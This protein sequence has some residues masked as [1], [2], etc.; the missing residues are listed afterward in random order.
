LLLAAGD[1]REHGGN[2]GYDDQPDVHYSWD[3][4]VHNYAGPQVGDR[5][6]LW[7]KER[8]LG[9]ST[10]EAIETRSDEKVRRRCPV[11]HLA[12]IKPRK[13]TTPRYKCYNCKEVFEEA[14]SRVATVT[15]YRTRH[16][17]GWTSLVDVL[18][19]SELRNLC[20]AP[21]SQLSLRPLRW[22]NFVA[23]ISSKVGPDTAAQLE[24]RSPASNTPG[25]H[26]LSTVRV[27]VGQQ[28]FRKRLLARQGRICAFTGA[29]PA[30]VLEAGHLYSY[31]E[32]GVHHEHGGLLLRRDIHRLFDDGSI[33]VH[34]QTLTIDVSADLRDFAQYADLHGAPLQ[35]SLAP[36]QSEWLLKHWK[37]HR[38][39]VTSR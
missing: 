11:C 23:A 38:G 29:A 33:T 26:A 39:T 20:E 19:G 36:G 25:G 22:A 18:S 30:A 35:V 8:L 15:T 5:I 6:A 3:S 1:D 16:D 7:D 9:A 34:P 28:G 37:Q 10:I 13:T 14:E 21:K 12:D 17:A 31:A 2:D 32:L 27:R 4:T 24:W